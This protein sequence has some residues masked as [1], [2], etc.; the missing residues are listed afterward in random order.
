M[1]V[2]VDRISRRRAEQQATEDDRCDQHALAVG[3]GDGQH[4]AIDAEC[5]LGDEELA[6]PRRDAERGVADQARDLVGVQAG[7]VDDLLCLDRRPVGKLNGDSSA[8]SPMLITADPGA[9]RRHPRSPR[10]RTRA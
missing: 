5:L 10:P 4:D 8:D 9:A 7:R 3:T 1:V 2:L 6:L